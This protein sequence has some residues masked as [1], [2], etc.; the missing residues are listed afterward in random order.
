MKHTRLLGVTIDGRFSWSHHLTDVK[1]NFVNKLEFVFEQK[2]PTELVIHDNIAI[3]FIWTA[4]GLHVVCHG[5]PYEDL[6]NSL[7]ILHRRVARAI[8]NL[9]R[10][11]CLLVKYTDVRN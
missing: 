5:C 2:C 7:E 3:S 9:P 10:A 8:Y 11:T 4:Y 1:K 6:L